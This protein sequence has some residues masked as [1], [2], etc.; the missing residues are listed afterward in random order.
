MLERCEKDYTIAGYEFDCN[1]LAEDFLMIRRSRTLTV[2]GPVKQRRGKIVCCN[3][4]GQSHMMLF[5]KN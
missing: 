2:K 4:K 1:V 3:G 5:T